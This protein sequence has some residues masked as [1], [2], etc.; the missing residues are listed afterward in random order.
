MIPRKGAAGSDRIKLE[1]KGPRALHVS[2]ESMVL[3]A[4]GPCAGRGAYA[5]AAGVSRSRTVEFPRDPMPS[6]G[7]APRP[8]AA[9]LVR[10]IGRMTWHAPSTRRLTGADGA[11]SD[12]GAPEP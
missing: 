4:E 5:A 8:A 6:R 9:S 10:L 7:W 3:Q 2:S 1:V 12:S 11:M